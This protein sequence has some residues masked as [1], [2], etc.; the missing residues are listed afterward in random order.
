MMANNAYVPLSNFRCTEN[1]SIYLPFGFISGETQGIVEFPSI[2]SASEFDILKD[3]IRFIQ[4][5]DKNYNCFS[6]IP[7]TP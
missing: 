3:V 4:K 6:P 2:K 5:H 1:C 7:I